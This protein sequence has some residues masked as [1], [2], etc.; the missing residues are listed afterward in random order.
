[1]KCKPDSLLLRRARALSTAPSPLHD[2]RFEARDR[3]FIPWLDD[4]AFVILFLERP[5]SRET[6]GRWP[7][8]QARGFPVIE[9]DSH[10]NFSG[11]LRDASRVILVI[12][13]EKHKINFRNARQ[14]C[15]GG[16]AIRIAAVE[17]GPARVDE[18][19]LPSRGDEE[20][21]LAAFR[22]DK[23]DLQRLGAHGHG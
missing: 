22:I 18:Q 5:D 11:K 13:S 14:F 19:R 20:R 17:A 7:S 23:I 6:P 10:R 12:V 15:N 16:N 3:Q 1:M 2:F 21:G 4:H 9:K 8:R